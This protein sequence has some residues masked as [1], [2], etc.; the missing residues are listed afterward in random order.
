MEHHPK[1]LVC[2]WHVDKAWRENLREKIKDATVEA[3]VYKMLWTVLEETSEKTFNDLLS[4][5]IHQLQHN[6]TTSAFQS[7][8][9]TQNG[10]QKHK[11]G[12]SAT[13]VHLALTQTCM[14]KLSTAHSNTIT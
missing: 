14:L 2:T 5:V 3:E 9:L 11:N 6:D 7:T 10:S 8:T 1:K 12:P 4:K 13:D